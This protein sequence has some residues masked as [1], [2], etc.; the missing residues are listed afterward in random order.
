MVHLLTSQDL[1]I[2]LHA[3]E[4]LYTM[5]LCTK[6]LTASNIEQLVPILVNFLTLDMSHFGAQAIDT[7]VAT[8]AVALPSTPSAPILIAPQQSQQQ[9]KV[10]QASVINGKAVIKTVASPAAPSPAAKPANT[11]SSLL[12]Q[13]LQQQHALNVSTNQSPVSSASSPG[14][15]LIKINTTGMPAISK[16]IDLFSS[17]QNPYSY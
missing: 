5:T 6:E 9:P 8:T 16:S 11:A 3:L 7:P 4:C 15:G 17:R 12:H 1:L 10:V 13:T 2:V 14:S